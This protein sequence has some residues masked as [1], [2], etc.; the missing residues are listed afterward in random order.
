MTEDTQRRLAAIVFA[1]VVGYSRLMSADETG[2]LA[3]LRAHRAELLDPLIAQHGGRIVKTMGDGLFLEFPSVVDAVKCALEIQ[4]GMFERNAATPDNAALRF[5]VGVHLGDVIFEGSDI[6]GDGVNIAARIETLADPDGIAISDDAHRQ[7]RDR[8]DVTWHDGGAHEVKTIPRPISVWRWSPGET[9]TLSAAP[10][11]LVPPDEPSIAVLPFD[12]RSGDQE[13]E[14]FAD[15]ITEDII[16]EIS[17]IS[18]LMV[19]SRNSTFTYKGM[20]TKAQDVCRDLG[21][22][23][24]L[25]GS[26]RKAGTRVRVTAQLVDG[27]SGGHVWAER[28]D[29]DLADIF[30]VQDDVTAKIVRALEVNLVDGADNRLARVETEIPEAYDY[31]LRGREQ[32][33][34]FTKDGNLQARQ[35]YEKAIELD[36]NYAAAYAGL[37]EVTRH[38]WFQGSPDA[39]DR[40]FELALRAKE[41]DPSLPLVYEALGNI[42]LFKRQF[43]EAIAAIEKWIEVEPSNADAYA[44]LAGLLHFAGEPEKVA[45]LIKKSIRLN[46]FY[47]FYYIL[48][49]GQAYLM[50]ERYEDSIEALTRSAARNPE[51]MPAHLYLAACYGH[52]GDE[53]AAGAAMAEVRRL[54]PDVSKEWVET[55]FAYKRAT[56]L[57]RLLT[58]LKKAGLS[59]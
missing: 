31:V 24:I 51:A 33:R 49:V 57:E 14:Y 55:V 17:K 32:Y 59:D 2:T 16:T 8:L 35:L 3:A 15:G 38:E 43:G 47:P 41:L 37:A 29:R 27:Q 20:A 23:Y 18:G 12:N 1:D 6:F 19:I 25:E 46:P 11:L 30:A 10:A 52:M 42:H 48:Y 9:P 53:A 36:P 21:V 13:Q 34:L 50:M 39:L 40:A 58:G 54:H 5:R 44:N 45:P 26:V 7:V 56:D 4:R 22:R 28:Y